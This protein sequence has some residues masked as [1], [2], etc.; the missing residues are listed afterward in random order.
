MFAENFGVPWLQIDLPFDCEIHNCYPRSDLGGSRF[1]V[2][3]LSSEPRSSSIPPAQ[4]LPIAREFNLIIT[5]DKELAALSNAVH[6]VYGAPMVGGVAGDKRFEVSF[7]LSLGSLSAGRSELKGYETR[8]ELFMRKREI[9]IPTNF[10]VSSRIPN[11]ALSGLPLLVDDKRDCMF[12]SM[13]H[14][15][16]ENSRE[17][18]YF[19]E[20]LV[21]CFWT[22]TVPIYWGCPNI[23][24]YFN[25]GGIIAAKT[26]TG[27]IEQVNRLTP[28]D[29]WSRATEVKNNRE[30]CKLYADFM[31][32]V[33]N[34]I[35]QAH[36]KESSA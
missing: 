23:G 25:D 24:E 6:L 10:Y 14:L 9:K 27:I 11:Y 15:A 31:E 2:L 17:E 3:L 16:I 13:F 34:T 18:D 20:K 35:L 1:K 12:S 36:S 4:L 33:R 30:R 8:L 28:Q 7:I 19:T 21:D 29:Y 5:Y 32:R 26:A 22:N